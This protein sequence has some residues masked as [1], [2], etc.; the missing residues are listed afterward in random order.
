PAIVAARLVDDFAEQ[1]AWTRISATSQY[2]TSDQFTPHRLVQSFEV[3]EC[4]PLDRKSIQQT[5]RSEE[6]GTLEIKK[7]GLDIDLPALR[8]KLKLSGPNERT[9]ILSPTATGKRAFICRR[10]G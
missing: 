3:L 10:V 4:L 9:L 1:Q 5:L 2:L 6:V 7:R 8:K